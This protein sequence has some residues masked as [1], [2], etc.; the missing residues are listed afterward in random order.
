MAPDRG[1]HDCGSGPTK[2]HAIVVHGIL[3]VGTSLRCPYGACCW[4]LDF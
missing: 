4:A 3:G 2:S 1:S